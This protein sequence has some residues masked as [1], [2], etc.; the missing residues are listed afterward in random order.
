M[1]K[2]Q[3]TQYR[4]RNWK[5]YNAALVKRGSLEVWVNE[6]VLARWKAECKAEAGRGR[7]QEY[8]D[9][10]IEMLLILG[11]KYKLTLREIEGFG[12][13]LMKRLG[14]DLPIPDFSTLSRRKA[15]LEVQ[16]TQRK[17]KGARVIAVDSS[18]LKVFGEGEWK[19]RQYGYSKHRT[20]RKIH[21]GIDTVTGELLSVEGS[22][23]DKSDDQMLP[24][25]LEGID[26][27]IQIAQVNGDGGYDRRRSYQAI[28]QR[29]AKAVIPPRKRAK[30]WQHGNCKAE[31]LDRDNNLRRIRKIGKKAWKQESG[32]HQRSKAEVAMYRYKTL[33]GVSLTSR[34]ESNQMVDI[35]LGGKVLNILSNLGMPD[36]FKVAA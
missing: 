20:W 2:R 13:S 16:I 5:E 22:T 23:N 25:V 35:K 21:L 3:K 31:R 17:L 4:I 10:Y 19:V 28:K 12:L 8:S 26:S 18:G 36:S 6:E 30:I 33:I 14:L 9:G 24:K 7:P 11:I 29:G 32:Y 15:K 27:Q 34:T 1:R